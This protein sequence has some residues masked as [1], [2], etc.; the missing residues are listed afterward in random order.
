MFH[1]AAFGFEK[2]QLLDPNLLWVSSVDF[3]L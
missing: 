1:A 2:L 3:L